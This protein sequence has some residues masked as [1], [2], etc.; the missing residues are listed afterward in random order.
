MGAVD[1]IVLKQQVTLGA[2]PLTAFRAGAHLAA[3]LGGACRAF[4]Q[5][6]SQ[7]GGKDGRRKT[8]LH[9]QNLSTFWTGRGRVEN[10][11]VAG[12]ATPYEKHTALWA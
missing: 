2:Y 10:A 9:L 3:E 1:L 12:G 7:L 11:R 8:L 5:H 6:Q 4:Q